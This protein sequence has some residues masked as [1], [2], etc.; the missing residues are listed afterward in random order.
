MKN[1]GRNKQ[2]IYFDRF[3]IGALTLM[4]LT[5]QNVVSSATSKTRYACLQFHFVWIL[6]YFIWYNFPWNKIFIHD[7]LYFLSNKTL[8][9]YVFP[10]QLVQKHQHLVKESQKWRWISALSC[11]INIPSKACFVIE[12]VQLMSSPLLIYKV[13]CEKKFHLSGFSFL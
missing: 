5:L 8:M 1:L 10:D 9:K 12:D 3:H 11:N 4:Q 2:R 6:W 7:V 13:G